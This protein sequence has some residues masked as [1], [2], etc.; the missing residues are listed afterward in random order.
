MVKAAPTDVVAMTWRGH[1]NTLRRFTNEHQVGRHGAGDRALPAELERSHQCA[2][3]TFVCELAQAAIAN[4][5]QVSAAAAAEHRACRAA[6]RDTELGGEQSEHR[7]TV[8]FLWLRPG[9]AL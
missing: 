1:D 3:R 2:G 7:A 8:R 9:A 4:R 6:A 5:L